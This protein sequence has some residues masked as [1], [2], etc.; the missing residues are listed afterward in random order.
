[1]PPLPPN[2]MQGRWLRW[3]LT[4]SFAVMFSGVFLFNSRIGLL[5]VLDVLFFLPGLTLLTRAVVSGDHRL[6]TSPFLVPL[7]LLLA[8]ALLSLAWAEEPNSS[9]TVRGVVQIVVMV[10]L[11]RWLH[12]YFRN[13][14]KQAMANGALCAMVVATV[15]MVSYYTTQPFSSPLFSEPANLIFRMPSLDPSLALMAMVAPTFILLAQGMEEGASGKGGRRLVGAGV[16]FGFLCLTSL[17]LGLMSILFA[18]AWLTSRGPRRWLSLI[19]LAA[20]FYLMLQGSHSVTVS[21]YFAHPLIGNGL[22]HETLNGVLGRNDSHLLTLAHPRNIFLLLIH[23]LGLIGLVLFV[24]SWVSPFTG[25]LQRQINWHENAAYTIAVV[26]GLCMTYAAGAYLLVP[27]Q[28][29]WLSLWLPLAL[30]LARLSERPAIR[31]NSR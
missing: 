28:A 5:N 17:P 9:R 27:F 21:N 31:P 7:Y 14:F 13:T 3:W 23:G 19:P 16:G 8:W 24:A 1:M 15:A 20:A 12:L 30:L 25:L 6:M 4:L 26:P 29:S 10:G 11:F 22:N 18:I 2:I